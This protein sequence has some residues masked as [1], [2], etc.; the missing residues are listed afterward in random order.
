MNGRKD[1]GTDGGRKIRTRRKKK[2][3]AGREKT[4]AAVKGHKKSAK[5]ES[6][7]K[8]GAYLR[9]RQIFCLPAPVCTKNACG[10]LPFSVG[11]A[12]KS[13][14]EPGKTKEKFADRAGANDRRAREKKRKQRWGKSEIRREKFAGKSRRGQ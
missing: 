11:S 2:T 1:D 6:N 7:G 14:K 13:E 5:S 4:A 8:M 12:G 9:R 3:G 10:H